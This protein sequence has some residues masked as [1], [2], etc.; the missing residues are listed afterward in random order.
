MRK[1]T[2]GIQRQIYIQIRPA[3]MESVKQLNVMDLLDSSFLKPGKIFIRQEILR[4]INQKPYA[5]GGNLDDF[6]TL[7]AFSMIFQFHL[8]DPR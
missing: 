3:Q 2:E 6:S 4:V 7:S 8:Y 5:A 1:M